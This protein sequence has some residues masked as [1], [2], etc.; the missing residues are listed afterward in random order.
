MALKG[1]GRNGL[2]VES[3]SFLT[4]LQKEAVPLPAYEKCAL[5]LQPRQIGLFGL[6][7]GLGTG[8]DGAVVLNR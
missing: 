1:G 7:W 2:A 3:C 8:V 6:D 5:G 4:D